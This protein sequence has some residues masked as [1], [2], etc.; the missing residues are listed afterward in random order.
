MTNRQKIRDRL[1][2]GEMALAYDLIQSALETEG[3]DIELLEYKFRALRGLGAEAEADAL[4]V[5][6]LAKGHETPETLGFRASQQ[7]KR[8]L[9]RT[10]PG[11]VRAGLEEALALYQH[12][13]ARYRRTDGW[14]Y[15][16]I[17][18][19]SRLLGRRTEARKAARQALAE[20]AETTAAEAGE[21][22]GWV[23]GT[24]G[25]AAL[26]LER[27]EEAVGH[28]QALV[29]FAREYHA[30]EMVSSVRRNARVLLHGAPGLESAAVDAERIES[31]LAT[32]PIAICVGHMVDAPGR[33]PVRFPATLVD[34][35]HESAEEFVERWEPSFGY[36]SLACGTD[37]IF[38]EVLAERGVPRLAVLPYPRE[39]FLQQS[40]VRADDC[41]WIERF[42]ELWRSS[43]RTN[44]VAPDAFEWESL[45]YDF[46]NEVT[47]GLALLK[48]EELGSQVVGFALWDGKVGDGPGGTESVIRLWRSGSNQIAVEIVSPEDLESGCTSPRRFEEVLAEKERHPLQE[49]GAAI[50]ALLFA[51]AKGFSALGE[52]GA[53][54]F[55]QSYLGVVGE[56]ADGYREAIFEANTWGDAVFFAMTDVEAAGALA[57]ELC[58]SLEEA[59]PRLLQAGL[60]ESTGLRVA[61]HAGPVRLLH[62]PIRKQSR[63]SGTQISKAARIEPVTP[64]GHVYAS[65]AFAALSRARSARGYR[66]R[67]VGATS[68]AKDYGRHPLY[69]VEGPL[70]NP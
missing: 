46:A 29:D 6:L 1:D 35:A 23:L 39:K 65:E 10:E 58:S 15:V 32:P 67:Y 68:L 12:A 28:Y 11:D 22:F 21:Q 34:R 64:P 57:L 62:D 43:D 48:A 56:V 63:V 70:S 38:H 66:C 54:A 7:K 9:R 33:K 20:V 47:L 44:E 16:N 37:I 50:M 53:E 25:E 14:Y 24:R 31:M 8:S 45:C 27:E 17:A 19:I 42:E 18:T 60:P 69:L 40:V 30:W 55:A 41:R 2:Q 36:G 61:L 59:R 3:P 49:E 26:V 52:L 51:D 4:I 5:E 13:A